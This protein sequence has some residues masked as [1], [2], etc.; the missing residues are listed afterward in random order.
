MLLYEHEGFIEVEAQQIQRLCR[1]AFAVSFG[2]EDHHRYELQ[3]TLCDYQDEN[4]RRCRI[5]FYAKSLKRSLVFTVAGS[6]KSSLWQNGQDTLVELGYQLED[7]NLKLSPA[8]LEVV[9][10]DVPGVATPADAKLH[11][12][13]HKRLLVELQ[14]TCDENPE[15]PQGKRA[16]LK[17]STEERLL[18]RSA[19]LREILE[20]LFSPED[21]ADDGTATLLTQ[22]KDL[23]AR[24][25]EAETITESERSQ[26]ELSEAITTAAEKRIQ[27]L[28]E[29]LVDVETRSSDVLKQKRKVVALNGRIKDLDAEL[30]SAREAL[31]EEQEKQKQ[32]VEDV[33][34]ANEQIVDLQRILKDSETLREEAFAQLGEQ[35]SEA[36][37]LDKNYKEAEL[38]IKD[39]ERDLKTAE[40]KADGL[41]ETV[42]HSDEL[43]AQLDRLEKEFKAGTALQEDLRAEL[44]AAVEERDRLQ[45]SLKEAEGLGETERAEL[46]KAKESLK[47]WSLRCD[48]EQSAR[49]ALEGE[50]E[51]AH[52]I[53]DSLEKMVRETED[54]SRQKASR[55]ASKVQDDRVDELEKRLRTLHDQLQGETL[56]KKTLAEELA[57]AEKKMA[58]QALSLAEQST[59][60]RQE[61]IL[62]AAVLVESEKTPKAAKLLPHELRPEPK[63]G[64][65]FRPDWDLQGLPCGSKAQVFKAWETVFN[66]Q[67][68]IEGYPSQYC[69]AFMAVLKHGKEKSLYLLYRLKKDKHTLV[70][71]PTNKP[72]DEASLQKAIKQGLE[73][74]RKS[75][76]EMDEMSKDHIES[77]LGNY[78]LESD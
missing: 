5:A 9:L 17:L 10:R 69:M 35:E 58:E 52:K 61:K 48:Q 20:D 29:I 38:R 3:A 16:A 57:A 44:S 28:E 13:E 23:T 75:G 33:K 78:F 18:E 51:E 34:S 76:F 45:E 68:A 39:L 37:Q 24:L 54:G 15:G 64:A 55:V 59:A 11:R 25:E 36:M 77:T 14:A 41:Q 12:S 56:V 21:N 46:V 73:F 26:K 27:E 47:E 60:N 40:G 50:L 43:R 42:K 72:E 32:F 66:V 53:I 67:M 74:L 7:V 71:V 8:M 62:E 22:I 30:V 19:V 70:C 65:F 6:E 4:E 2:S 63:K 1:S 31:A 49:Q